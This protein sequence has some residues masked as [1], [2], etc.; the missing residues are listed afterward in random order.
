MV[1]LGIPTNKKIYQLKSYV[2]MSILW[3]KTLVIEIVLGFFTPWCNLLD[4]H[5]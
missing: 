1:R 3:Q 4:I 5:K 2:N